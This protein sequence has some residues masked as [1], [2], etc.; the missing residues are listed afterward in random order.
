MV[1]LRIRPGYEDASWI[2]ALEQGS[3]ASMAKRAGRFGA[4][5]INE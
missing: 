4:E 3:Y 1:L 5:V 2:D